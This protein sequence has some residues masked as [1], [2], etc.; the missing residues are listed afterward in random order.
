MAEL[1]RNT[2]G[3]FQGAVTAKNYDRFSSK[4]FFF[5]GDL[6]VVALVV[7]HAEYDF[8]GIRYSDMWDLSQSAKLSSHSIM[9]TDNGGAIGLHS[10]H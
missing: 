3:K 4:C 6:S 8:K 5:E 10:V 2:G 9:A 1:R 7:H